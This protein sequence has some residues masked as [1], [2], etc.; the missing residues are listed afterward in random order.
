[1]QTQILGMPLPIKIE[2][3][4]IEMFNRCFI[5]GKK[6]V[7]LSLVPIQSNFNLHFCWILCTGIQE[8]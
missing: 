2:C 5:L 4:E 3:S 7:C 8:R 1:M 6:A